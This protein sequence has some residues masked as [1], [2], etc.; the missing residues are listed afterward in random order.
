M[1]WSSARSH[2]HGWDLAEL[3]KRSSRVDR[4]PDC[5]CQ[6]RNGPGSIPA[7]SETLES[8]RQQTKQCW[9]KYMKKNPRKSPCYV[10]VWSWIGSD[11]VMIWK[12]GSC[13]V[14]N[15]PNRI[16]HFTQTI[17]FQLW[18]RIR[19]QM[20]QGASVTPLSQTG[21]EWCAQGGATKK[22]SFA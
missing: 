3:W 15:Q 7:S 22:V 11:A 13:S 14:K 8:K 2:P 10:M 20:I 6:S 19:G 12:V 18:H 4:A 5:Q 17:T 21:T 16:Q 9:I 1:V